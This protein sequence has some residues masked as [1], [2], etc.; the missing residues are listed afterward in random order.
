M[1]HF[2]EMEELFRPAKNG[3]NV[4]YKQLY[5][6]F[7]KE[8]LS[9]FKSYCFNMLIYSM[10]VD[11]VFLMLSELFMAVMKKYH[12]C[13]GKFVSYAMVALKR[14]ITNFFLREMEKPDE[15]PLSL[16]SPTEDGATLLDEIPADDYRSEASRIASHES[17][18]KIASKSRSKDKLESK[19]GKILLYRYSGYS[20]PEICEKLEITEGQ[21]RF[22]ISKIKQDD[23]F[24]QLKI[25]LK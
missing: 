21:L 23:D 17:L 13:Y 22:L 14:G 7:I 25:D 10:Y 2:S 8:G 3:D 20:Y 6:A 5:D 19:V 9:V 11:D 12:Y 1:E 4:A 18:Y 24:A 15:I 16:D